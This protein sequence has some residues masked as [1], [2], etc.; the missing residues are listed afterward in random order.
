MLS[1]SS[2]S[3]LFCA[4]NRSI[5]SSKLTI[6]QYFEPI[7]VGFCQKYCTLWLCTVKKCKEF[8]YNFIYIIILVINICIYLYKYIY[9]YYIYTVYHIFPMKL[10]IKPIKFGRPNCGHLGKINDRSSATSS[11]GYKY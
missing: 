3:Q 10:P 6:L 7:K 4:K 2:L 8:R 11:L 9:Y 1:E 5:L